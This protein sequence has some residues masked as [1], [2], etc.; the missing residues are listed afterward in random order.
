MALDPTS[1]AADQLPAHLLACA[2][3]RLPPS[4]GLPGDQQPRQ[5]PG[6]RALGP[7]PFD[8][9]GG[10]RLLLET[11]TSRRESGVG[12][13]SRFSRFSDERLA[14]FFGLARCGW[15][16]K[17]TAKR[18]IHLR[19]GPQEVLDM[20]H[21]YRRPI[22]NFSPGKCFFRGG[23]VLQAVSRLDIYFE[24]LVCGQP[25]NIRVM[26]AALPTRSQAL[27]SRAT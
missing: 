14:D 24:G 2:P 4:G 7:H 17:N 8:P 10:E 6:A 19:A 20:R 27:S 23:Q 13:L 3:S 18:R 26:A 21:F 9:R 11:N 1:T 22:C 25:P 15:G 12:R 16:E 5:P